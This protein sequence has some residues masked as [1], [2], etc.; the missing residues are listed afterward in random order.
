MTS[1]T[2]EAVALLRDGIGSEFDEELRLSGDQARSIASTI[3]SLSAEVERLTA[4]RDGYAQ[5]CHLLTLEQ[6]ELRAAADLLEFG[7]FSPWL[8]GWV[9][10]RFGKWITHNTAKSALASLRSTL[11]RAK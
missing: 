6:R 5:A 8:R 9:R 3:Q 2:D 10:G 4:E 7:T 1:A 11:D